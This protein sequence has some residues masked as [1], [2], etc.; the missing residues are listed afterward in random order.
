M[1]D[2]K[3]NDMRKCAVDANLLT[4]M[5]GKLLGGEGGLLGVLDTNQSP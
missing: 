3:S 5:A 2:R 4:R 1:H